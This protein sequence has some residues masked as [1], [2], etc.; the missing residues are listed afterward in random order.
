METT[1]PSQTSNSSNSG[2]PPVLLNATLEDEKIYFTEEIVRLEN[3]IRHLTESNTILREQGD[4]DP[5]FVL[6]IEEN[7]KV[8]SKYQ[9]IIKGIKER[10]DAISQTSCLKQVAGSTI[11]LNKENVSENEI[12]KGLESLKLTTQEASSLESLES[13]QALN[14]SSEENNNVNKTEDDNIKTEENTN[15]GEEGIFL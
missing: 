1:L 3:S 8:I 11:D 14:S 7:E 15:N 9:K 2:A 6:A 13:I 4:S 10:L 12:S 5:D